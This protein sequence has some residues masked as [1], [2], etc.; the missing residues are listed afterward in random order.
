MAIEEVLA[1]SRAIE[2][3][4][5]ALLCGMS[6]AMG[7]QLFKIGIAGD[8]KGSIEVAQWKVSLDR[9]GPGIFFAL[10]GMIGLCVETVHSFTSGVTTST[11][12]KNTSYAGPTENMLRLS[13]VRALNR[14]IDPPRS[15][16]DI[17]AVVLAGIVRQDRPFYQDLRQI[18]LKAVFTPEDLQLWQEKKNDYRL[19]AIT[20]DML[21]KRLARIEPYME[22]AE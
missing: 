19:G 17:D 7:Y 2:R 12:A 13:D 9:V 22:G 18:I 6:I 3:P 10:F 5:I 16:E 14:V 8:Q 4:L 20:D 15:G 11:E 21:K 1:W